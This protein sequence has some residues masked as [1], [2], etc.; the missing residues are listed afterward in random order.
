MQYIVYTKLR[1]RKPE[2]VG[3]YD[4]L[5]HADAHLR[6]E[7][8]LMLANDMKAKDFIKSHGVIE[9]PGGRMY[10]EAQK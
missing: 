5:A 10:I 4:K 6:D 8:E 2:N 3:E 9:W 1:G 7:L